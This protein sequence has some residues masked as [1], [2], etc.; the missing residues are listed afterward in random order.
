MPLPRLFRHAES[1]ALFGGVCTKNSACFPVNSL[2][3]VFHAPPRSRAHREV[4][5][6]RAA[7]RAPLLCLSRLSVLSRFE[8]RPQT[9]PR[10][11]R[12]L[13]GPWTA[14][15]RKGTDDGVTSRVF[16]S[17]LS[18]G[19]P[20]VT[21]GGHPFVFPGPARRPARR[22][23]ATAQPRASAGKPDAS[24]GGRCRPQPGSG[25]HRSPGHVAGPRVIGALPRNATLPGWR[26]GGGLRLSPQ[27]TARAAPSVR[28][29]T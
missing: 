11:S 26:T 15:A 3:P 28:E 16:S 8:E 1:Y 21:A 19:R 4:L 17:A 22:V 13:E 14:D 5:P 23:P 24:F 9:E 18:S 10:Q 2:L 29:A 27:S 25:C 7:L 12:E 6:P 20:A